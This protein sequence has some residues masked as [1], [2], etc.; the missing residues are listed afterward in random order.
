MAKTLGRCARRHVQVVEFDSRVVEMPAVECKW[1]PA[2]DMGA[3]P[4]GLP[5]IE[6][7]LRVAGSAKGA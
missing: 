3:P 5:L 7:A 2:A 6:W 1:V 4:C